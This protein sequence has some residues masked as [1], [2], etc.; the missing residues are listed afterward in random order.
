MPLRDG[1]QFHRRENCRV[2]GQPE[3]SQIFAF[4]MKADSLADIHRQ[5][6]Q[7]GRLRYHRK[8]E[9]LGHKLMLA[10]GYAYLDRPLH[11]CH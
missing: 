4:Q 11:R 8:V 7:A 5:V 6:I 10:F 2:G 1:L 3:F 9:T